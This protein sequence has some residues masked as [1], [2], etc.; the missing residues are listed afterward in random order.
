MA[1][2]Q[3]KLQPLQFRRTGNPSRDTLGMHT[4]SDGVPERGMAPNWVS[5]PEDRLLLV[6]SIE[7]RLHK[8]LHEDDNLLAFL[9]LYLVLP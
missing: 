6:A 5:S 1:T 8:A 3:G 7:E 4:V 2:L 9:S